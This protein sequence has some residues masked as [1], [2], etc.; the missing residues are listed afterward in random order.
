MGGTQLILKPVAADGGN[1]APSTEALEQAV[2]IIRQRVDAS[3]VA[4]AEIAQQG[5]GNIVVGIP[6]TPSEEDLNLVSKS[7]KMTF[8]TVLREDTAQAPSLV[9]WM[10]RDYPNP[11]PSITPETADPSDQPSADTSE[12][13]SEEPSA[14][15]SEEP[16]AAASADSS[17]AASE[18]A[19]EPASQE[20]SSTPQA[21]LLDSTNLGYSVQPA[22]YRGGKVTADDPPAEGDDTLDLGTDGDSQIDLSQLTEDGTINLDADG[23]TTTPAS[24]EPPTV[25]AMD[26][27]TERLEVALDSN[28][29]TQDIEDRYANID[30]SMV[31]S[32]TSGVEADPDAPLVTCGEAYQTTSGVQ[33]AKYILGPVMLE[34]KEIA[35]ANNGLKTDSQ[36]HTTS[37]WEVTLEFKSTGAQQFKDITTKIT[38]LTEPTNQFAIVLDDRVVSAP[39][40]QAA[41]P[42]G[43]A[44]ITGNFTA[45]SSKALADQLSFGALP[46]NF[47]VQSRD[48]VSATLGTEALQK[49]LLAGLIGLLL[50]ALYSFFQYRALAFVTIA[51]LVIATGVTYGTLLLLSWVQGYRLSLAGVAGVIVSIGITADSF[52]VY[53]ER[54]R[55]ELRDG[56]GLTQAVELAWVRARKTILAADAVNF[57]AAVVLYVVSVGGVR[58]FAYTLGLTTL[59]D[60]V[61]VMMFTHPMVLLVARR[62][63]WL[64]GHPWSGLDPHRLGAPGSVHYAGRLRV[65]RVPERTASTT[66]KRPITAGSAKKGGGQRTP[67]PAS[68]PGQSLAERKA[69]S[70]NKRSTS[71]TG[72]EN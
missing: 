27:F 70:L 30:C 68:P 3:G 38:G 6:G 46:L 60:L 10:D 40:S 41:I 14:A 31:G 57:I 44:S 64:N 71:T 49:G 63:F 2:G 28:L 24:T 52:V 42:D 47:V 19:S 26:N 37:E 59:I 54:I 29:I 16:S 8:R 9:A 34:G 50:V 67:L 58:G 13:A 56:R 12:A 33:Y 25:P 22:A 62:P 45:Q 18:E 35:R 21:L 51:S 43:R 72:E 20:P 15:A 55:D 48:Q 23:N 65:S 66:S 61:V 39:R 5:Q 17:A 69:A 11:S 7:A 53:F 32:D 4:E 1:Q 36:G